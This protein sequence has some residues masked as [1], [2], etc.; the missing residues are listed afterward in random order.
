MCGQEDYVYLQTPQTG[1][2]G[3]GVPGWR[4]IPSLFPALVQGSEV[5]WRGK[6]QPTSV[7]LPGKSHGQ[8]ILVDYSPWGYKR[9]RHDLAT[10]QQLF[11]ELLKLP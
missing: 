9:V 11:N 4:L 5:P 1:V 7:F 10:K 6:W 3:E 2:G 8:S